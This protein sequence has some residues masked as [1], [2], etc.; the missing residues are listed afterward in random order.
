MTEHGQ[1]FDSRLTR[2]RKQLFPSFPLGDLSGT[3]W[4]LFRR[5]SIQGFCLEP[6]NSATAFLLFREQILQSRS[7]DLVNELAGQDPGQLTSIKKSSR[8]K[9]SELILPT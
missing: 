8:P 9:A 4:R 3:F 1:S 7:H 2:R 5:V 6:S